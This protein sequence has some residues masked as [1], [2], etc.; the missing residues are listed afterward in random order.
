MEDLWAEEVSAATASTLQS[1]ISLLRKALGKGRLVGRDGGYVLDVGDDELDA[2]RFEA[3]AREGRDALVAGDPS[4]AS[5]LLSTA[6]DR[7]HGAAL[8]DVSG[9]PWA[10]PEQARLE[11]LRLSA[12]ETWLEAR[13]AL[14]EHQEVAALAEAA[15][16]DHPLREQIWAHLMVALYRSGRQSDALRTYQ[17]LRALLGEELGIE[18]SAPLVAL[19]DA[20]V[21]QKPELDWSGSGPD[22]HRGEMEGDGRRYS[23]AQRE[24]NDNLPEEISSFVGRTGER[25]E[26]RRLI[27]SHRLVTLAGPGGTGKT[28]LALQTAA[29]QLPET[30]DGVWLVELASVTDGELVA[31]T[32]AAALGIAEQP[33]R[34]VLDAL[35]DAL[36]NKQLLLV[37][38]NCEHLLDACSTVAHTLLKECPQVHLLCTSREPLSITG[39][40]VY[41]V[42]PLS[43]PHVSQES[44]P[45]A[46]L[47]VDAVALFCER[48]ISHQPEFVL[49]E[50]R[51]AAVCSICRALDGIPLALELAAARLEAMSVKDLGGASR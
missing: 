33:D 45:E 36:R 15:V 10:R 26:V 4:T 40:Y 2:R 47:T 37:L 17:R 18:P 19:D 25:E 1:H 27:E 3:E 31:S 35:A 7:W 43:L 14:G 44:S 32:C 48:A 50:R 38:D 16:T 49:D 23:H 46:L 39:E 13:L 22:Y 12:F 11:E 30:R 29:G 42:P 6:L 24:R 34:L 41:R 20:I 5:R 51:S 28:R 9:A 21:Q 8:A